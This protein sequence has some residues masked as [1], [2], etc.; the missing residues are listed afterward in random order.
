[1]RAWCYEKTNVK[2]S[3]NKGKNLGP[4]AAR[5]FDS[6]I[7]YSAAGVTNATA[8]VSDLSLVNA[9]FYFEMVGQD[10]LKVFLHLWISLVKV[11]LMLCKQTILW[12]KC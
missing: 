11:T 3:E 5:P 12:Y 7:Q 4:M 1:M 6:Q 2:R 10:V 8:T 9:L